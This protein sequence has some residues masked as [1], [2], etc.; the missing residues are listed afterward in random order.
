[1]PTPFPIVVQYYWLQDQDI[2]LNMTLS[3]SLQRKSSVSD[4]SL[5]SGPANTT[6][7]LNSIQVSDC[8]WVLVHSAESWY[9]SGVSVGSG[10]YTVLLPCLADFLGVADLAYLG[11]ESVSVSSIQAKLWAS[12]NPWHWSK[13]GR[14]WQSL[15]Q[16]WS[17]SGN[18]L[19]RIEAT[20]A[21]FLLNVLYIYEW[22]YIKDISWSAF[23]AKVSCFPYSV[24]LMC[25]S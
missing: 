25:T 20:V 16:I 12:V 18:R 14:F 3:K 24:L 19:C 9:W 13:I 22:L 23:Y 2:I 6:H 10:P 21:P 11:W 17:R 1:M 5:N 7:F 8:S 4:A 15:S